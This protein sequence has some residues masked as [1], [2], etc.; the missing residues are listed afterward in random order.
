[1]IQ[2]VYENALRATLLDQVI[3]ATDHE[4]ILRVVHSF[5][6]KAMM[7]HPDHQSGTDRCAEVALQFP[8]AEIVV[9]IQGDEP[10][11]QP[12]QIDLIVATLAKLIKL[13]EMLHNPNVV[14]VVFSKERGALYF[15]RHAIPYCRGK[16]PDTWLQY[17]AYYKH[18]GMYAYRANILQQIAQLPPS[19]LE[20]A[21]S[22]E[23]LRWLEANI[24]I[25]VGMTDLE[26]I[27][28]DTPEDLLL[29]DN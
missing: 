17:A 27:G 4:E 2:L 14:K 16:Q 25:A 21:E 19:T 18:I 8:D 26:T 12:S 28:I 7:T 20:L 23:Q 9:N 1:M 15:S 29:I 3:V 13:P 22:L 24:S 6:G 5:G 11:L 10:F